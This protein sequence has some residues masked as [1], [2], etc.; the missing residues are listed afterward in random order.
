MRSIAMVTNILS[1]WVKM[2]FLMGTMPVRKSLRR[3]KMKPP[4]RREKM[5]RKP[6]TTSPRS[7]SARTMR[8]WKNIL[9][10]GIIAA[11]SQSDPTLSHFVIRERSN[12]LSLSY[13]VFQMFQKYL[14]S[15]P[16]PLLSSRTPFQLNAIK[17]KKD[18]YTKIERGRKL[19]VNL[20]Y[21]NL[22]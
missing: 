2:F 19:N 15:P 18:F 10:W 1:R 8:N 20:P 13:L 17:S 16:Q 22:K 4:T 21:F 12:E 3:T 5:T 7:I 11:I 9:Q 6:E 14:F